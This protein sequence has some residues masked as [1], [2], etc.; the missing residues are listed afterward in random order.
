ML[1]K[2]QISTYALVMLIWLILPLSAWGAKDLYEGEATVIVGNNEYKIP[3]ECDDANFPEKGFSTEPSRITRERTGRSSKINLRLRSSKDQENESIISLDRYIAWIS[4]PS[5][6]AG[7]LSLTL[8]MSPMSVT[9]QGLP[10]FITRDASMSG[11]RP[12]GLKG[13]EITARCDARDP[14]V[15]SFRRVP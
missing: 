13:V 10:A 5:S 7:V 3:I 8:D 1:K 9:R 14:E 15:P 11:D 6:N 12:E 4:Q 2:Q